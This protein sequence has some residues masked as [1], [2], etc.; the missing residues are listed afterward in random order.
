[1]GYKPTETN[2]L[3]LEHRCGFSATTT[4]CN[5]GTL[6]RLGQATNSK[7]GPW[8][9]LRAGK[10]KTN[11]YVWWLVKGI[12]WWFLMA[13]PRT[14]IKNQPSINQPDRTH[15]SNHQPIIHHPINQ[16]TKA[17]PWTRRQL[18]L[19]SHLVSAAISAVR[20][21]LRRGGSLKGLRSSLVKAAVY[22]QL[23]VH[24]AGFLWLTIATLVYQ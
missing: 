23:M 10:K 9:Q 19:P 7:S 11:Q 17:Q 15:R 8:S 12:F 20:G 6:K 22:S 1:M 5:H 24:M 14:T 3:S 21:V 13:W 4:T 16:S 18:C 2:F